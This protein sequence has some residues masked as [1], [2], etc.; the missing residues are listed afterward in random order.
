MS[1][2]EAINLLNA[3]AFN[4]DRRQHPRI[5]VNWRTAIM[6]KTKHETIRVFGR[7][8]DASASGLCIECDQTIISA[9]PVA[10]MIE[11]PSRLAHAPP[12]IIHVSAQ[13]RNCI[14]ACDKYR[15]GLQIIE[16]HGHSEQNMLK[17]LRA[18]GT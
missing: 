7:T 14:L 8:K 16:F 10:V 2:S 18:I 15:M 6:F 9:A 3:N 12:E 5:Y 17:H 13:I 1:S 4:D 11:L